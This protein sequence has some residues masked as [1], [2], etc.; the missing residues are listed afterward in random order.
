M[1]IILTIILNIILDIILNTHFCFHSCVIPLISNSGRD[2]ETRELSK[3][4]SEKKKLL[5]DEAID[6]GEGGGLSCAVL[7]RLS[8]SLVPAQSLPSLSLRLLVSSNGGERSPG[9]C[10]LRVELPHDIE[11]S[12]Y[13]S[14]VVV[15][16]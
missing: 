5:Q 10:S 3:A 8:A 15:P 6:A 9:L 4:A 12:V 14:P 7:G 1:I 16:S 13:S 11:R 2:L